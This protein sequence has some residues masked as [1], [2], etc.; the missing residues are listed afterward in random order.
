MGI[1][2]ISRWVSGAVLCGFALAVALG[3]KQFH[4]WSQ[5]YWIWCF[6]EPSSLICAHQGLTP[7]QEMDPSVGGLTIALHTI[8]LI[9]VMPILLAAHLHPE[10]LDMLFSYAVLLLLF[11]M[12][13]MLGALSLHA[14]MGEATLAQ[15]I[16][17]R[18]MLSALAFIILCAVAWVMNGRLIFA[19]MAET[20]IVYAYV[21]KPVLRSFT[22]MEYLMVCVAILFSFV[23]GMTTV[24]VGLMLL[25][26]V[27]KDRMLMQANQNSAAFLL[28]WIVGVLI[29][30]LPFLKLIQQYDY[31]IEHT[32]QVIVRHGSGSIFLMAGTPLLLLAFIAF[33]VFWVRTVKAFVV[34]GKVRI[35][36]V[37]VW[38]CLC[39]G[40]FG[41]AAYALMII[42]M[43]GM[44][45][46]YVVK[47]VERSD[48]AARL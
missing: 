4:I 17:I 46:S 42:P 6:W 7:L 11:L 3:I 27:A 41:Y 5:I 36:S 35:D 15:N 9:V 20:L 43:V 29:A 30:G 16:K 1:Y 26:W 14:L 18:Q 38:T 10:W 13:R 25:C 48:M 8:R 31:S 40:F 24:V 47:W 19:F 33:F 39:C 2:Q 21:Q 28:S 12:S 34:T 23:S 37:L 32:L 44:L 45:L 22:A